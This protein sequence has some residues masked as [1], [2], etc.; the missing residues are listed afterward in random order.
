MGSRLS[1]CKGY[2]EESIT[3]TTRQPTS[4]LDLTPTILTRS[5][6]KPTVPG[7]VTAVAI[8]TLE[9]INKIHSRIGVLIS[10][11]TRQAVMSRGP[12]GLHVDDSSLTKVMSSQLQCASECILDDT[13]LGFAY[14]QP[15]KKCQL[16][17]DSILD[18]GDFINEHG[19]KIYYL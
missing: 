7:G 17:S 11:F 14:S 1:M 8:G 3:T 18:S 13:C 2:K 5:Q 4:G 9:V 12:D 19:W 10:D 6:I 16:M 15:S